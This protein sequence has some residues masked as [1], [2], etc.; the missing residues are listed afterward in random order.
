MTKAKKYLW[1]IFFVGLGSAVLFVLLVSWGV[2]GSLP[3]LAELENPSILSASEVYAADGRL[4]GKYYV[5]YERD[6]VHPQKSL[7][8]YIV[9]FEKPNGKGGFE[10]TPNAF[11]NYKGEQGLMANPDAKH[12]LDHDIF[13]YITSL[14]DPSKNKD[15]SAF[16]TA[17]LDVGDTVFYSKGFAVLEGLTSVKEVPGIEFG[18]NDSVTM[19][20]MKVYSKTSPT[21]TVKPT[22]INVGNELIAK[23][24]E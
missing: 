7:W 20:T 10:L 14:P 22:I 9:K 15:T 6:S 16:K 19:A 21:Y 2:F 11:V 24:L 1:R 5:T 8:Y 3:S 12:Y 13:T 23:P 18:P 4:M 17:N